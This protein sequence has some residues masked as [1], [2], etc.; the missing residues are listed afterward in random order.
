M[1]RLFCGKEDSLSNSSH[2]EEERQEILEEKSLSLLEKLEKVIHSKSKVQCCSTSKS[3][4]L[5]KIMKQ[6][7][8]LFHSTENLSSNIIKLGE[9]LKTIPSTSAEAEREFSAAGLFITKLRTKLR[10][11]ITDYLFS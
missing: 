10:D 4:S 7:L 9:A 11:K 2:S 3:S 1:T 6:E 8:Q 5:S